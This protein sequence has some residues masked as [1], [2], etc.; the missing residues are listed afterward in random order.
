[1]IKSILLFVFSFTI[2]LQLGFS[3]DT[4]TTDAGYVGTA[5]CGLCH[6]SEKQGEQLGIWEKSAHAKA[7]KTLLT[8]EANKIATERGFST[9]A[10]ETEA[11]L[12]C[13]VSGYNVDASML[14]AKFKIEDGVQCET[15]HGPG[16]EY[17]SLKIMKDREKSIENGLLVYENKEELCKKC[18]NEE[19]PSYKE[20]NF[21]EM[22]AKIKHDIPK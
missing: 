20:F 17:K 10:A 6:K 4:K 3:S 16:S 1:M 18:H 9:K 8:D 15:C 22:W 11:C 19:S 13:H 14:G 7:Y 2:I 5:T 21:E 12:K